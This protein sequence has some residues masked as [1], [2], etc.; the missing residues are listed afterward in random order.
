MPGAGRSF[1]DPGEE[2]CVHLVC[3]LPHGCIRLRKQNFPDVAEDLVRPPF[4]VLHVAV[5]NAKHLRDDGHR[6]G[7][8]QRVDQVHFL[9]LA[10]A[11][12]KF[13]TAG[14]DNT[15]LRFD[16]ARFEGVA[17]ELAQ[18][19]VDRRIA[20]QHRRH[21]ARRERRHRRRECLVITQNLPNVPVPR[22]L[23]GTLLFDNGRLLAQGAVVLIDA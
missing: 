19:V 12:H 21:A 7:R 6:Q 11:G 1:F 9:V 8:R 13:V 18:T 3:R 10:H 16:V 4:E 5:F 15:V 2:I 22:H 17:D 14:L 23:P 20:E